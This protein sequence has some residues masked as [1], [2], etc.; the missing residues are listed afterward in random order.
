MVKNNLCKSYSKKLERN[1]KCHHF[2][3]F[4]VVRF[5]KITPCP[6]TSMGK[7]LTYFKIRSWLKPKFC[8]LHKTVLVH[9]RNRLSFKFKSF[10]LKQVPMK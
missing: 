5:E 10:P 1:E 8:I 6:I 3:P 2:Y 9:N 4:T 7:I